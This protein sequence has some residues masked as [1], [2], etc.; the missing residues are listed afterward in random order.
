MEHHKLPFGDA[1]YQINRK[2]EFGDKSDR[3][4]HRECAKVMAL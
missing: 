1:Y 2:W 4:T 3:I